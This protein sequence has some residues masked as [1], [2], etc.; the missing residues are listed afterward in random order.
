MKQ[1]DELSKVFGSELRRFMEFSSLSAKELAAHLKVSRQ[2]LYEYLC[3]QSL[4]S[5]SVLLR[6]ARLGMTF[7][8]G[9]VSVQSART[10]LQRNR[11]PEITLVRSLHE[12][13]RL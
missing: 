9:D 1:D 4:P 2:A 12:M 5:A 10:R 3:G 11:P 7:T 8:L 13:R 6:A